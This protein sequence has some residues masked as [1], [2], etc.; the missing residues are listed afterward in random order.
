L[1]NV[2]AA[3]LR[4]AVEESLAPSER[5]VASL[6]EI[7]SPSRGRASAEGHLERPLGEALQAMQFVDCMHQRLQHCATLLSDLSASLRGG[8]RC[9]DSVGARH[10]ARCPSE[11]D[12]RLAAQFGLTVGNPPDGEGQQPAFTC[13]KRVGPGV[14]LF[15]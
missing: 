3:Q 14:E 6:L 5:I 8:G 2:A 12:R 4:D 11:R 13:Q 9:L 10:V 7:A 15:A 1:L